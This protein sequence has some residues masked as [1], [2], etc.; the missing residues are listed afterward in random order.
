MKVRPYQSAE[1]GFTLIELLVVI[2]IIGVLA[3]IS[4]PVYNKVVEKARE[5]QAKNDAMGLQNAVKAFYTEYGVYPFDLT[6]SADTVM[7]ETD[8][9]FMRVLLAEEGDGGEGSKVLN[10]REIVY[11]A[12][13][14]AK[15]G[16]AGVDQ[17]LN[18]YDP[19]GQRYRVFMDGDFNSKITIE[20]IGDASDATGLTDMRR[21]IGVVSAGKPRVGGDAGK[22]I[23]DNG[24]E[25]TTW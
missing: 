17:E 6:E 1:K 3:A 4:F 18:F 21:E 22:D 10:R 5:M 15:N 7:K 14:P 16:R 23:F 25:V 20:G 12:A 19:W 8:G 9:E 24:N 11:F 2:T 13:D